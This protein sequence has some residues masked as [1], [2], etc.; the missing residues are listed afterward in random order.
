[1]EDK[2]M[3]P[4]ANEAAEDEVLDE[5]VEEEPEEESV[6]LASALEEAGADEQSGED[7]RQEQQNQGTRSEPG[8][9]RSRIDKAVARAIAETEARMQAKFDQQMAPYKEQMIAFEAQELVRTGKVKDL[10]TAKELVRYRQGQPAQQEQPQQQPRNAQGQF[11]PKQ[12]E[13]DPGT[14]ARI[15]MLQHQAGK[16]KEQRGIDVIAEFQKNEEVKKKVVSGEWDFYDVADAMSQP[17]KKTPA[18]MRSPNG[19]SGYQ[20][21]AID[22]MSDEQFEKL[23]KKVSGGARISLRR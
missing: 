23:E 12:T 13:D 1:M 6:D 2:V 7:D 14:S 18:P 5:V 21:N 11:A 10:E 22:T 3:T 16:I 8:Y 9:V 17:K 15:D 19:A 4:E 20:L